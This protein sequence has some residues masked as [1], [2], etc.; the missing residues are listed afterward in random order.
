MS[1]IDDE[2]AGLRV[3][4]KELRELMRQWLSQLP[5][6]SLFQQCWLLLGHL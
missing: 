6:E 3:A 1:R 2:M 4:K 5:E